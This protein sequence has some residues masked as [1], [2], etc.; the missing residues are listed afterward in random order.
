MAPA[1][2]GLASLLLI[3]IFFSCSTNA[4]L[5]ALYYKSVKGTSQKKMI[6]FLRGRGGS[7]EDFASDGMI[8]DIVDRKLPYDMVAPNAHFGYYFG[9]T[10]TQRLKVDIIEPAKASGY[11]KFWMVGFSM[12]GLGALMYT[13][14]YPEDVEGVCLISPFLGYDKIIREIS[15][16]GGVRKWQPGEYNPDEDWQRMFWDWLKKGAEGLYPLPVI[17]L[18]YGSEDSYVTADELLADLL[19]RDRVFKTSGSHTP[20]TMKE[21]WHIFLEKGVLKPK[22]G[23][24]N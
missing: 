15:D 9:K 23:I 4:P 21:L 10:L 24:L 6:I 17:Y 12:G 2:K 13:R 16:A 1:F 8:N 14:D 7:H 18:G 19:P 22:M 5:K 20:K 11:E 3:L